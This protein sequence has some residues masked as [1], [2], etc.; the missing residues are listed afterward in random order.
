VLIAAIAAA[1]RLMLALSWRADG[2]IALAVAAGWVLC[3][4]LLVGRL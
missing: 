2:G 4:E 1:S 3:A